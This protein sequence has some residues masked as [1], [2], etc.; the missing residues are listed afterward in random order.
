MPG[1]PRTI[2][3]DSAASRKEGLLPESPR[4]IWIGS[5]SPVMTDCFP[6]TDSGGTKSTATLGGFFSC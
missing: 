6:E 1:T 2:R 5:A 4:T 3:M